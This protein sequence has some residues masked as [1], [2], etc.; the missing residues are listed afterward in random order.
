MLI[1][2]S[3]SSIEKF[4]SLPAHTRTHTNSGVQEDALDLFAGAMNTPLEQCRSSWKNHPPHPLSSSFS[5][6]SQK[7]T[8]PSGTS[9]A[10][11]GSLATKTRKS[12]NKTGG[13]FLP[14]SKATLKRRGFKWAQTILHLTRGLSQGNPRRKYFKPWQVEVPTPMRLFQLLLQYF[15]VRSPIFS[16]LE[17]HA[18]RIP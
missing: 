16:P 18:T 15:R 3:G 2:L 12:E 10:D 4:L 17:T 11:C 14:A 8:L 6:G 7:C 13:L 5:S 1:L 9:A